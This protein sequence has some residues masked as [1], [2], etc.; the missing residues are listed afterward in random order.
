MATKQ[1]RR[2]RRVSPADLLLG[3]LLIGAIVLGVALLAPPFENYV[4]S[5][6]R[7]ALL[8]QQALAL[9]AENQRLERRLADLDDP[10]TIELL[11]RQQQ[12]LVRPGEVPYVLIP[13]D[14]DVPRIL[15]VPQQTAPEED[16]LDRLL[17]WL[18]ARVG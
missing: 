6:Q 1:R 13:P 4:V 2:S 17:A 3:T 11:A 5:R 10:L 8:E 12:G 14:V 15:D 7:V 9:D 18:R 16:V